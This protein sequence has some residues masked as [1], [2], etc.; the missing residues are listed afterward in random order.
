MDVYCPECK[1]RK[2]V[3]FNGEYLCC[4]CSRTFGPKCPECGTE[5]DRV[6]TVSRNLEL[7]TLLIDIRSLM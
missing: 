3:P 6:R 7:E 1:S 5:M 4:N 2:F